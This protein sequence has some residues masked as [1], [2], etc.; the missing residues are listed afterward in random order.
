MY[1]YPKRNK[2]DIEKKKDIFKIKD[3]ET[4]NRMRKQKKKMLAKRIRYT[5]QK[6]IWVKNNK[7][8][9]IKIIVWVTMTNTKLNVGQSW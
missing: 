2:N 1:A 8:K 3:K 5:V 9:N 6:K 7:E 4:R